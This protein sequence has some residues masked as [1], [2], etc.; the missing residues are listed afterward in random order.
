M[1]RLQ[2]SSGWKVGTKSRP[3]EENEHMHGMN[4]RM[5]TWMKERKDEWM[6]NEGTD[7]WMNG[8]INQWYCA[9]EWMTE[10]IA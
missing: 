5:N 3:V 8:Q 1:I 7:E 10:F 6:L 2:R 4:E 9:N